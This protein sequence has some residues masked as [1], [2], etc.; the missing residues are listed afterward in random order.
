MSFLAQQKTKTRA[1]LVALF[2]FSIICLPFWPALI[3]NAQ[4]KT[5][6]QLNLEIFESTAK[7]SGFTSDNKPAPNAY[8]IIGFVIN[9]VLGFVGVIFFILI[10]AG[11]FIWMTASGNEEKVGKGRQ[12]AVQ[13]V[14]GLA[15][16]LAAYLLTNFVVKQ[17]LSVSLT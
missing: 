6:D 15:I 1:I 13:S 8:Q 5:V 16:V 2:L 9:I 12:L 7:E 4:A 11:G 17:I 10:I 14:I 3:V